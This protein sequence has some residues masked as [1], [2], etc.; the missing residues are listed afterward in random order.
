MAYGKAPY[1]M[2]YRDFFADVYDRE[3]THLAELNDHMLRWF[4][5]TLSITV[6]FRLASD[7]EFRGAKSDLVL[8]MCRTL[9]TDRFIFGA[10]GRDY[11]DVEAFQ[12]AGIDVV[13][14]DYRHP[15]YP[16]LHGGFAPYMSVVDL[17]FNCG[18]D[19]RDIL[20][21]GQS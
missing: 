3:W 5:D 1:F 10:M 16:Q 8:D 20:L 12:D 21:S 2:R 19:S 9:G 7:Y 11:A 17:L 4:L 18:D 6:D 13:F 14:Q 15:V